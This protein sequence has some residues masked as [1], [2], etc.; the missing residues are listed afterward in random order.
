M[1][2]GE[3][4]EDS[5]KPLVGADCLYFGNSATPGYSLRLKDRFNPKGEVQ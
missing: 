3:A 5:R 4:S 2:D 1:P